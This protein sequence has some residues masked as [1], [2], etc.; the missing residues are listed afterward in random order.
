MVIFLIS[1][2]TSACDPHTG[3]KTDENDSESVISIFFRILG[4]I[5]HDGYQ[6]W[7]AGGGIDK[8]LEKDEDQYGYI[9]DPPEPILPIDPAAPNSEPTAP[10]SNLPLK[11]VGFVNYGTI[12]ATVRPWTYVPLGTNEPQTPAPAASTVSSAQGMGG[13]WPN[14]SRFI[15]VPL[16]TY[17]WCIDWE[18]EDQDGDGYFDYYHYFETEPTLLDEN[19][20]DDLEL[21]EEVSISAPPANAPIYEGKCGE[22]EVEAS[23]YGRTTYMQSY[24]V[25]MKDTSNPPD[26]ILLASGETSLENVKLSFSSGTTTWGSSRI[27]WVAGVWVEV[28]TSAPYNAMGV[29]VHGD[30]TI[31]WARVLFDGN[32]V[33]RGNT[34]TTWNDGTNNGVYVEMRCFPPGLHTLR[35]ESLGIDGGGGGI[36]VPVSY[37]GF[38]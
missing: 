8:T 31:G 33:W 17:T 36:T 4:T 21:A 11:P 12:N 5:I 1:L 15:S 14:S 24:V 27:M 2:L 13:N 26:E 32:E 29:Q 30:R 25:L 18:E 9:P 19:D 6:K 23:C 28:S 3:E 35:I 22:P 20:S 38:R 10:M 16:G 37:F 34:A 7:I